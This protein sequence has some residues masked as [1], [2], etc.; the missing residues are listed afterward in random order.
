[1]FDQDVRSAAFTI[2]ELMVVI[3]II[4]VLAAIA[5]PN[6]TRTI[7]RSRLQ[8]ATTQLTTVHAAE[9]VYAARSGGT[10]WPSDGAA[11]GVAEINTTLGVNLI[12]NGMAFSC[13]GDGTTFS[14]T[15]TRS[16]G[17]FT[18]TVDENAVGVSNPSCSGT[19]P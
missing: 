6:Y 16:G 7:E 14:C 19:C 12:E 13:T 5:L 10:Y 9:Q 18:V 17:A 15:G 4:G 8:D 11:H 1:M 2:M 3:V